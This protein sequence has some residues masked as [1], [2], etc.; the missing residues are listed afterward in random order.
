[1]EKTIQQKFV[2]YDFERQTGRRD[3]GGHE[4]VCHAD[5]WEYVRTKRSRHRAKLSSRT[6]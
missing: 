3:E 4:R 2:T 1:M 5:Y 6:R